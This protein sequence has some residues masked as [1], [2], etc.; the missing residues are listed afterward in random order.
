MYLNNLK[1]IWTWLLVWRNTIEKMIRFLWKELIQQGCNWI[2]IWNNYI[3]HLSWLYKCSNSTID[4][5]FI[6]ATSLMSTT[7]YVFPNTCDGS[8]QK[9]F[10]LNDIGWSSESIKSLN[11][12]FVQYQ[13]PFVFPRNS[14]L[15]SSMNSSTC[16]L[17][18]N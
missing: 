11:D 5:R 14:S 1:S 16:Y 18:T 4:L 7:S 8:L 15:L 17:W 6:L 12:A 2:S 10:V 9:G 3:K 13:F